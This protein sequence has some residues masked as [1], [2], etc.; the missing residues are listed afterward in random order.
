VPEPPF[1]GS[2]GSTT[3]T[4]AGITVDRS[5]TTPAALIPTYELL[6]DGRV[7]A[8]AADS[9]TPAEVTLAAGTHR[10]AGRAVRQSGRT[11]TTAA[12]TVAAGTTAPAFTTEPN[13]ALRI[14]AVDTAAV[15]LTL[16]RTAPRPPPWT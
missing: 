14:G 12:A 3:H 11:A 13:P 7:V 2:S 6:V 8:T 16:K 1:R 4:K 15:P 5:A 10:V 9:A